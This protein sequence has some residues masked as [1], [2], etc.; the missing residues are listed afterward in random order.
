MIKN[1]FFYIVVI[2]VAAILIIASFTLLFMTGDQDD[3]GNHD[4]TADIDKDIIT[5]T[6][7]PVTSGLVDF[8]GGSIR[9]SDS[10]SPLFGLSIDV[11][12]AATD[13]SVDFEISYA[14]VIETPGLPEDAAVASK[15]IKIETDGSTIWD[16]YKTFDKAIEVTLPYDASLVSSNETVRYYVY[17]EEENVLS[18][19]GFFSHDSTNNTISFYT[20]TFSSFIAVKLD[21]KDHEYF[22][23]EYAVDTGFRPKNDGF[24]IANY[25]SYLESGGMCMG[26]TLMR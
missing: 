6:Y 14:D 17:D 21:L 4:G 7:V 13:E 25:G 20:R 8:N 9:V 22:G 18:S 26:M 19:A 24:F 2:A 12:Q 3:N 23:K 16:K 15:M 1:N 11:P 10:S 5:T